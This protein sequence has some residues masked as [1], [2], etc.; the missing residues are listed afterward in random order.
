MCKYDAYTRIDAGDYAMFD[1]KLKIV[2]DVAAG[3]GIV[4][5]I[6]PDAIYQ[7]DHWGGRFI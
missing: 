4:K 2:I 5:Y 7:Y 1:W 3:A 6:S